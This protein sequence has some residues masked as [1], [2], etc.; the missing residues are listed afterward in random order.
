MLLA[1]PAVLLAM[2]S[3]SGLVWNPTESRCSQ[4]CANDKMQKTEEGEKKRTGV[5]CPLSK[6]P[7]TRQGQEPS[8]KRDTTGEKWILGKAGW[9]CRCFSVDLSLLRADPGLPYARDTG[10]THH[11][12]GNMTAFSFCQ[13]RGLQGTWSAMVG[14][15]QTEGEQGFTL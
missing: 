8:L 6:L 7:V 11:A 15:A 3:G 9:P 13:W 1:R 4:V 14:S 2:D 5:R 10:R 12:R